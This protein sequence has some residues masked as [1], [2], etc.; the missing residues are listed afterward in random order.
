MI[1][2]TI[3]NGEGVEVK[4]PQSGTFQIHAGSIR[5]RAHNGKVWTGNVPVANLEALLRAVAPPVKVKRATKK[6][7][8]KK[9][10]N[11]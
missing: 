9:Q 8:A 2:V 5:Y 6:K 3:N 10:R 7:K 4:T 1:T 11:I